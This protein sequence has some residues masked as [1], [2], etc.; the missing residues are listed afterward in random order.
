MSNLFYY[1]IIF[2]VVIILVGVIEFAKRQDKF[3]VIFNTLSAASILGSLFLF[4]VENIDRKIDRY[5]LNQEFSYDLFGL[6]WVLYIS[7]AIA[8]YG[9][10]LGLIG[11]LFTKISTGIRKRIVAGFIIF[12][13]ALIQIIIYFLLYARYST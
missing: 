12:G 6:K 1:S 5:K 3:T 8:L 13:L 10:I 11:L 2:A 9:L 7:I 4:F